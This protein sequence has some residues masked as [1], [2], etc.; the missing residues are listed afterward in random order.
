MCGLLSVY[1]EGRGRRFHV[2]AASDRCTQSSN[3]TKLRQGSGAGDCGARLLESSSEDVKGLKPPL[4]A[5]NSLVRLEDYSQAARENVLL[6]WRMADG[7]CCSLLA[8]MRFR[9]G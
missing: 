3:S 7:V 6:G 4:D 1:L 2:P 8:E 9:A 5:L